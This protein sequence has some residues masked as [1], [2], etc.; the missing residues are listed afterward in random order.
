MASAECLIYVFSE[1]S[2]VEYFNL[3]QGASQKRLGS[4]VLVKLL[5]QKVATATV[6]LHSQI[7]DVGMEL[8][9]ISRRIYTCCSCH[10]LQ[11]A[12]CN[13]RAERAYLVVQLARFFYITQYG[14]T[15]YIGIA[16]V[17]P[18]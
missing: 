8:Y 6:M 11:M 16:M 12:L 3:E 15:V 4:T 18:H 13:W 1:W 5:A 9:G 10:A 7:R 17:Y 14:S 2:A